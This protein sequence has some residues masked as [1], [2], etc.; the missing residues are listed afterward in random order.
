MEHLLATREETIAER[1]AWRQ[2]KKAYLEKAEAWLERIDPTPVETAKVQKQ[3]Q[4]SD[5]PGD[6]LANWLPILGPESG[7]RCRYSS[8]C[9]LCLGDYRYCAPVHLTNQNHIVP[10]LLSEI[11]STLFIYVLAVTHHN[12]SHWH[13]LFL[14]VGEGTIVTV[15]NYAPHHEVGWSRFIARHILKFSGRIKF[16]YLHWVIV[17]IN[18]SRGCLQM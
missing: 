9:C 16:M 3:L 12:L 14:G 4:R 11:L 13:A 18:S 5:A 6:G 1:R 7:R 10:C 8:G 17:D 2:G 15:P